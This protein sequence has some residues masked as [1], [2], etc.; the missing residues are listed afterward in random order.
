MEKKFNEIQ[1][2][3]QRIKDA[4]LIHDHD[5]NHWCQDCINFGVEVD[6][7]KEGLGKGHII[8]NIN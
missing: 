7:T 2:E 6:L 3:K 5:E 1:R 8:T 4:S